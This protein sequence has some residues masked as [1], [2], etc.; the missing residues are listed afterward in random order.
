MLIQ[1]TKELLDQLKFP[2]EDASAEDIISYCARVSNPSNQENF[3]TSSKLLKYC[4][5]NSHWSIFEMVDV[6]MEIV[7][8]RDIGRQILRHKSSNFQ[9]LSQRYA[10]VDDMFIKEFREARFQDLKNRQNSIEADNAE[11]QTFWNDAQKKVIDLEISL[12]KEA[13]SKGMA[14]EC[15]R[16]ILSEGLV[17]SRMYMKNNVR[18]W[19]HYCQLRRGNGTQKEHRDIAEKAW[20]ELIVEMPFLKEIEVELVV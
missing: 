4:M 12:Y 15:A 19:F 2:K 7:T 10:E 20:Q 18:G 16:S 5:K 1:C 8:T 6:T 11:L 13:I 3:K 9:E 14:K 17:L